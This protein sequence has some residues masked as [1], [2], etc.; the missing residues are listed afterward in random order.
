MN[1]SLQ[2]ALCVS[3]EVFN[4]RT[5]PA[6]TELRQNYECAVCLTSEVLSP[7]LLLGKIFQGP[8]NTLSSAPCEELSQRCSLPKILPEARLCPPSPAPG[9]SPSRDMQGF[10]FAP[11]QGS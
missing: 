2:T 3:A 1:M 4:P 5:V 8:V 10:L 9:Q 6:L 11:R 7:A